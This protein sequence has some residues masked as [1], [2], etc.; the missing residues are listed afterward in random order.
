MERAV[1]LCCFL[2]SCLAGCGGE[3]A[4]KADFTVDIQT[5]QFFPNQLSI[6]VGSTVRW[7]NINPRD[8]LRTVTSGT[9]PA[10]SSAG[11]LFDAALR[12]YSPGQ[13]EGE[14]FIYLFED[15]GTFFYFSRI[16]ASSPFTGRVEV[17]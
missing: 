15:R 10:D 3:E 9:G 16:P 17:Q 5:R 8:S 14:D 6:G 7:V 2:G 13:A 4:K 1:V 11:A 12:G